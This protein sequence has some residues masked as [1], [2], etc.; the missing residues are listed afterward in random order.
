M[1][2]HAAAVVTKSPRVSVVMT[3]YNREP[4]IAA[5]I[6]SVLAQTFTDFELIVCD[7][8]SKDRTVTVAEEYARRD[9]RVRVVRHAENVGDYANRNRGASLA[10]GE[11]LKYHDSDDIMYPHCLA[12]MVPALAAEPRAAFALSGGRYWPGGP[13]PMLLTPRL[14]YEREF[15]GSGLFH[16]GPSCGLFRTEFFRSLGGFPLVGRSVA[17]TVFWAKAC[18]IANVLLVPGDLFYYRVHAGQEIAS[19]RYV[20]DSA[21]AR[22][23]VWDALNS[24]DCP[25]HGDELEQA[26]RNLVFG[27]LRQAYDYVRIGSPR[28]AYAYLINAALGPTTWSRYLRRP[29]RSTM[30]GTPDWSA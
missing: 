28:S 21:H 2:S 9:P 20:A 13:A 18:A 4:L 29:R 26:K 19:A 5:A 15:L 12:V 30:A 1:D 27:I 8:A 24:P 22:R 10:R 6:E 14:A 3:A 11:L 25:L 17:D 23:L 7:D 16:C